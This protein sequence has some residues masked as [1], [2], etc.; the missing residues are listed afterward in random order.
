MKTKLLKKYIGLL[1]FLFIGF[2]ANAH[3]TEI[4]VNQNQDGTLTWYLQTYHR[5]NECGHSNAGLTINGV[6]YNISSEHAGSTVGLSSTV[7]ATSSY[8]SYGRYSYAIVNTPYIPGNLNVAP[9]SNNACWAFLVGGNGSFTPPPPPV[10]TI[11]PINT[12]SNTV[13]VANN[14]GTDC[15]PTDDTLPVTINVNHQSCGS[16]TN[17]GTFSVYLAASNT[18]LGNFAYATGISTNATINL[19]YGFDTNT[20]I[21]VVDDSFGASPVTH[22]L[23]GL[24]GIFNGTPST[25]IPTA[26]VNNFSVNL[27][28]SGNVTITAADVDAGSSDACGPVTL[29]I[30]K[31]SFTCANVGLNTVTLTVTSPSGNQSTAT[32][33]VTVV[34]NIAPVIVAPADFSV[35]ATSGNGAL[36][37]Y[38][39]PVATDN[40]SVVTPTMT[41][42]LASGATFPLGTTLVT[43]TA[44][45]ASGNTA[46]ASFNVK[47]TGVAPQIVS[48][49]D[50]TVSN[51]LGQCSAKVSYA[52][53][54]TVGIPASVITYDIASG[55]SFADGTTA[56]TATATNAL[57]SSSVTFNVTVNDTEAP[58]VV[59]QNVTIALDAN[60]KANIGPNN[61]Y[62]TAYQNTFSAESIGAA[63]S[64]LVDWNVLYGTVDVSHFISPSLLAMDLAGNNSAQ[65]RTKSPITLTPGQYKFSIDNKQNGSNRSFNVA[66]G[67]LV[68]QNF[69]TTANLKTDSVTFNVTSTQSVYLTLTQL[70]PVING[71]DRSGSFVQ[72]IVISKLQ[73]DYSINNNSTDNCGIKSISV[74]K[75]NFDCSNV[76]DNTVTLTVTDLHGNV[77]TSTAIVKVVDNIVPT[78][79]TQNININLDANGSATVAAAQI[80]NGSTDNCTIN[81]MS[82]DI[83]SFTCANLGPNTVSLTVT[84]ASGNTASKT[85]I[86]TVVDNTPPTVITQPLSVS[87]DASG[88]ASITAAQINNNSTD[89]CTIKTMSIDIS[90]FT[91][92]NV[93]PNTVTLTVTD[94]SGNTASKTAV[95]TVVDAIKPNVITKDITVQ[96]DTNG[97]ASITP[98]QI[99]NNSTD[100]C[101]I[102]AMT[103]DISS[104]TCANV[105]PN[106]VSLTVTDTSGN[107]ASAVATVNVVDSVAPVVLT[108]NITLELDDTGN[109]SITTTDIDNG[110]NDAC[111]IAS[112]ALNM[113]DFTCANL[114]PNTVV[115]TATDVNG[116]I[117]KA[118]AIV[119]VVD[120]T[121]PIITASIDPYNPT[122]N[123]DDDNHRSYNS[124]K[125]SKKNHDK[126]D[127]DDHDGDKYIIH[128]S[129]D[130]A[131]GVESLLGVIEI[132]TLINP[133]VKLKITD[134][135][136]DKD[137][138]HDKGDK[139]DDDNKNDVKEEVKINF[140]KNEITIKSPN[141]QALYAFILANGG[142]SVTDGDIIKFKDTD[143]SK[144][145]DKGEDHKKYTKNKN[146]KDRD[147]DHKDKRTFKMKIKNGKIVS[148]DASSMVLNVTAVDGSGNT[149]TLQKTLSTNTQEVENDENEDEDVNLTISLYPNPSSGYFNVQLDNFNSKATINIYSFYGRLIQSKKANPKNS[150]TVVKMGGSKLRSGQYIV[151]V[152]YDNKIYTKVMVINK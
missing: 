96:L 34:D 71:D 91:C 46:S 52:A 59:T 62:Q 17:A 44:T 112:L 19:P 10:C 20:A 57:G 124:K 1:L 9:Y 104:F 80:N 84:D 11:S 99:N 144:K 32:A 29:S 64:T 130:D 27:N 69:A 22:T 122:N 152:Y 126:D 128:Y 125:K 83:S 110:S 8:L 7:F 33:T 37:N 107:S 47:V 24:S 123:N 127:D 92:A 105:G 98:N 21:K 3:V 116:N 111:G 41:A 139:D 63:A 65:I 67:N 5:A 87:L 4:R 23:S 39:A 6:R 93:G 88:N 42:G 100:N 97:A 102:K 31:T 28:V 35:F 81:S 36:V 14:N 137:D 115:L 55:S 48:P 149:S 53:T 109:A 86:V 12:W 146:K 2:S 113:V 54:E 74:S 119:T 94:A 16:I 142:V 129:A 72:N 135:D 79:V 43:Y 61:T 68:N 40:C 75:S 145:D 38:T 133:I 136:D 103:L 95:V 15:N 131:C 140:K 60:G 89:N 120:V 141:P 138:D 51:D 70:N 118:N 147:D 85:A 56:V 66:L 132:P 77:A 101:T 114:G 143:A 18:L 49:G 30:D 76:G 82:L 78:V 121:A 45:D 117:A 150:K 50:I 106:T 108:N 151:K 134:K 13:G 58:T 25:S 73:S 148:L 90:S 26:L